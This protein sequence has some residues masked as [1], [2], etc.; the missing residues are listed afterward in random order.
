LELSETLDAIEH[1]NALKIK[2]K[3]ETIIQE[4]K[5]DYLN[6]VEELREK[7]LMMNKK[8]LNCEINVEKIGILQSRINDQEVIIRHKDETLETLKKQVLAKENEMQVMMKMVLQTNELLERNQNREIQ[9]AAQ[10]QAY[11]LDNKDG[12]EGFMLAGGGFT[13]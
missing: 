9:S 11:A 4:E 1:T 8:I 10:M 13:G 2:E 6:Q 12:Y 5:L 3:F 7:N